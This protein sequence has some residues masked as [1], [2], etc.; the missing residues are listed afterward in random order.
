LHLNSQDSNTLI[1]LKREH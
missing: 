1:L